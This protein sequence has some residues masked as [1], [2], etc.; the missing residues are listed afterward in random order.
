[1][2]KHDIIIIQDLDKCGLVD[3]ANGIFD[4]GTVVIGFPENLCYLDYQQW[5]NMVFKPQGSLQYNSNTNFYFY[6]SI[7]LLRTLERNGI[8]CGPWAHIDI[9]NFTTWSSYVDSDLL[10]NKSHILSTIKNIPESYKGDKYF[11]R[12][13]SGWKTFTGC[14]TDFQDTAWSGIQIQVKPD[15]LVVIADM[16]EVDTEYRIFVDFIKEEV[17]TGTTYGWNSDDTVIREYS[18]TIPQSVK[19]CVKD[20]IRSFK[21]YHFE[22]APYFFIDIHHNTDT[23]ESLMIEIGSLHTCGLYGCDKNKFLSTVNNYLKTQ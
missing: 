20:V 8:N 1:M 6:G 15:T 10:F 3:I 5:I 4:D 13:V 12:P 18:Q 11:V 14:V 9:Y 21:E 2:A 7:T 17:I 23:N 22:P 19:D 16:N